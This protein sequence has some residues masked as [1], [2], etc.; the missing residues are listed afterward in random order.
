MICAVERRTRSGPDE[1]TRQ[2]TS[3][4]PPAL[5]SAKVM[6]LASTCLLLSL[7][8][9]EPA[10]AGEGPA[11]AGA[12]TLLHISSE[13]PARVFLDGTKDLG[14]SPMSL[15]VFEPGA[16]TF[17]FVRRGYVGRTVP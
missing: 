11:A 6:R 14:L 8:A 2:S 15:K 5:S 1:S 13:P 17:T 7:L 3:R 10:T 16:H 4:A 9:A 12:V